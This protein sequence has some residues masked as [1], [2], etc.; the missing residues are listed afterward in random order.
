[1][2]ETTHQ[3]EVKTDSDYTSNQ[4][5]GGES[6][7]T[8]IPESETSVGTSDPAF[9]IGE[10]GESSA[11]SS[12]DSRSKKCNKKFKQNTTEQKK[13]MRN[14]RKKRKRKT[15]RCQAMAEST[16]ILKFDLHK[17]QEQCKR[18]KAEAGLYKNMARTYWD[19]WQ[20]ELQKR[21]EC[22]LEQYRPQQKG[23][24]AASQ[25]RVLPAVHEISSTD[26]KDPV[27]DGVPTEIYVG[28]GSFSVVRLQQY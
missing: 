1:M 24:G 16:A 26:L 8:D 6:S 5:I 25:T 20:W 23:N 21:R 15:H 13:R 4:S 3:E 18:F 7:V 11:I 22:L 12:S 19:R 27:V 17:E 14:E 9:Y 2:N 28:R 10:Q